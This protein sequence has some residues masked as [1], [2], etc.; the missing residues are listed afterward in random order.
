MSKAELNASQ[1]PRFYLGG[2]GGFAPGDDEKTFLLPPGVMLVAPHNPKSGYFSE[3]GSRQKI[4]TLASTALLQDAKPGYVRAGKLYFGKLENIRFE[5]DP[6]ATSPSDEDTFEQFIKPLNDEEYL[7]TLEK[8]SG[9]LVVEKRI[10]NGTLFTLGIQP[11]LARYQPTFT[12][13]GPGD[14][15]PDLSL[16]PGRNNF[17]GSCFRL[18]K[19]AGGENVVLVDRT[20][21]LSEVIN[22]HQ[23]KGKRIYYYAPCAPSADFSWVR[24]ELI[25]PSWHPRPPSF[26]AGLGLFLASTPFTLGFSVVTCLNFLSGVGLAGYFGLQLLRPPERDRSRQDNFEKVRTFLQGQPTKPPKLEIVIDD[27]KPNGVPTQ[28]LN[29]ALQ[30]VHL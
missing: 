12:V 6:E 8:Y 24:N 19:V 21:K 3:M 17:D 10:T 9:S 22:L 25:Q 13:Y 18:E 2:H 27:G 1:V 29:P 30:T 7:A 26:W 14:K 23:D 28:R 20:K 11:P 4:I 5:S 15:V 16:S